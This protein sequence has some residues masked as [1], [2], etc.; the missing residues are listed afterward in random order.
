MMNNTQSGIVF[1]VGAGPGDPGLI[2][3]RAVE[4]LRK[5]DVVVYDRLAN[6]QLLSYAPQATWI[7]AGKMPSHH[8]LP[9]EQINQTLI[10]HASQGKVV[11]RLKGG[12]PFVFGRGGEEAAALAEA[13][14]PFEIVPGVSSAIAAP[15]YAGIPITYRDLAFSAAV[16]TGHRSD[17]QV[18]SAG[19]W[20][21]LAHSADTLV[22]L[23]GV[24]NL[25]TITNRLIAGGRSP[26]TPVAII[27]QGTRPGQHT[28][29]GT[30]EDIVEKATAIQPPAVIV[31]GEVVRLRPTL[32]WFDLPE[33]RPL[34]GWR[35]LNPRSLSGRGTDPF[36]AMLLA[37]GA[38]PIDL[39]TTRLA[40]IDNPHELDAALRRLSAPD[41]HPDWLI[42]TSANAVHFTLE[43]FSALNVPG[44][45]RGFDG[46][47]L[48]GV[49][50]AVIGKATG[51]ALQSWHLQ[52]D[53]TAQT[54]SA[55]G[56]AAELAEAFDLRQKRILIP[57][58]TAAL[59]EL[60][61]AL[62]RCGA[63]VE[64]VSA[65]TLQ[66]VEPD[67]AILEDFLSGEV[68]A[69]TF[70]SPSALSGLAE[71]LAGRGLNLTKALKGCPVVCIGETTAA[72]AQKLGLEVARIAGEA[73][74]ERMI[75]ALVALRQTAEGDG[76]A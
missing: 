33:R 48:A 27:A 25:P 20:Q 10:E 7:D 2:T 43:R 36:S 60:P 52:P 11:V 44:R 49:Q 5:A 28:V 47:A 59:D 56:L 19:D 38:E 39:A 53:F 13:G 45:A 31:V 18:D 37:A 14:I 65:Y 41:T 72:A 40:P 51:E 6:R 9:Q 3:L 15:A 57:R 63:L 69:A 12:D 42:F 29:L 50:L 54:A 61:Q 68:D 30:L 17:P 62:T 66:P 24:Q 76:Y 23:M 70:L 34:L 26:Q 73:T 32:R 35:V 75:E 8:K 67:P 16:I 58:S 21:R 74:L 4:C 64:T 71:C 46:R 1:L 22:F 55:A